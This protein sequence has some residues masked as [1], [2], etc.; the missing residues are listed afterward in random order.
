LEALGVGSLA[1]E[2]MLPGAIGLALRCSASSAMEAADVV[3]THGESLT[4]LAGP[5]GLGRAARSVLKGVLSFAALLLVR[6][7]HGVRF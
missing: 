6:P 2:P 1:V 3:P 7:F 4:A 5:L